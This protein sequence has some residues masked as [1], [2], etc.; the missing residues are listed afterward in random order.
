MF[1]VSVMAGTLA[2]ATALWG[3]WNPEHLGVSFWSVEVVSSLV[4]VAGFVAVRGC[5][6]EV[7]GDRV[8]DVV[9]WWTV[10]RVGRSDILAARVRAGAWRWFEIELADARYVL[11]GAGP[12]Q[13]PARLMPSSRDDDLADLDLLMGADD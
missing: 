10:R 2:I 5:F 8:R 3:A 7:D 1:V 13:F 4:C 11:L 6:V 9:G 12:A